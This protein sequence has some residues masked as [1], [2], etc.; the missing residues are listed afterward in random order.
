MALLPQLGLTAEVPELPAKGMQVGVTIVLR[1]IL[2]AAV[3]VQ[4]LL[5]ELVQDRQAVTAVTGFCLLSQEARYITA[6][7]AAAERISRGLSLVQAAWVAG[8]PVAPEAPRERQEQLIPEVA[9]VPIVGAPTSPVATA[10][11]ASRS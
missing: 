1:L 6:A 3:A 4:V 5:V 8:V 9:E 11:P 10:A 7:A 2:R